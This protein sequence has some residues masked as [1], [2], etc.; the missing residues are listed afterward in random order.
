MDVDD[1]VLRIF[2][3]HILSEMSTYSEP[4][5]ASSK[6]DSSAIKPCTSEVYGMS[7]PKQAK[8]PPINRN[9]ISR[10]VINE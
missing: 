3:R 7:I 9:G 5:T 2:G 1:V 4:M 6:Q 10:S 8:S